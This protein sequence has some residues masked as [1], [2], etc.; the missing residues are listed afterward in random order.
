MSIRGSKSTGLVHVVVIIRHI[1]PRGGESI[2]GTTLGGTTLDV[3]T[4]SLSG[5]VYRLCVSEMPVQREHHLHKQVGLYLWAKPLS[6]FPAGNRA[7]TKIEIPAG[8][9]PI[10]CCRLLLSVAIASVLVA[11]VRSTLVR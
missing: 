8:T 6:K 7:S 11:P 1:R 3:A 10:R 2:D 4:P 9:A 5:P